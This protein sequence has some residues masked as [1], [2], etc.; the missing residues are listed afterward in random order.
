MN[1]DFIN[2]KDYDLVFGK[3]IIINDELTILPVY[4]LKINNIN[5][6]GEKYIKGTSKS[7][8]INPI[9]FLEINKTHIKT[10]NLNNDFNFTDILDK[11]PNIVDMVGK[12]INNFE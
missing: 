3:K 6:D 11:A 5:L 4:N 2:D 7:V 10:H 12:I 9:C 1:N 8:H